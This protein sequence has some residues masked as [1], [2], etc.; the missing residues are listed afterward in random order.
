MS[1]SQSQLEDIVIRAVTDQKIRNDLVKLQTSGSPG[2]PITVD[3]VPIVLDGS[4]WTELL[5]VLPDILRFGAFPNVG[6]R[7]ATV[8]S[9]GIMQHSRATKRNV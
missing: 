4:D 5:K 2:G 8:W 7:D 9:I 6:T 3:G 1:L